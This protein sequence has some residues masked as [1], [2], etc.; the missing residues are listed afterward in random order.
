MHLLDKARK[1]FIFSSL[2]IGVMIIIGGVETLFLKK[3][4]E[5]RKII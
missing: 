1:I 2:L 4:M 3:F 5:R